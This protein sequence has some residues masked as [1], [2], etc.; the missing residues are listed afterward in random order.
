MPLPRLSLL[1]LALAALAPLAARADELEEEKDHLIQK[2]KDSGSFIA[3]YEWRCDQE[4]QATFQIAAHYKSGCAYVRQINGM[5]PIRDKL[6]GWLR[7]VE[8]VRA[9]GRYK[10]LVNPAGETAILRAQ[11]GYLHN[12][13][14]SFL[15]DLRIVAQELNPGREDAPIFRTP[16]L[17]LGKDS[18]S[19][20]V[21]FGNG[22]TGWISAGQKMIKRND[23]E[24]IFSHPEHGELII[25]RSSGLLRSQQL[26]SELGLMS[27]TLTKVIRK[28]G[29]PEITREIGNLPRGLPSRPFYQCPAASQITHFLFQTMIRDEKPLDLPTHLILREEAFIRFLEK[30]PISPRLG[31]SG[32]FVPLIEEQ[33]QKRAKRLKVPVVQVL[34]DERFRQEQLRMF[35]LN[36]QNLPSAMPAPL[37]FERVLGRPLQARTKFEEF[38]KSQI[39]QFFQHCLLR[40]ELERDLKLY[41]KDL[42]L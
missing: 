9:T 12:G 8:I 20:A 32:R 24:V 30:Q 21:L 3:T 42:G 4:L 22:S 2:L 6:R 5:I 17:L 28:P 31:E 40:T 23:D 16:S 26:N 41:R 25:E 11:H 27:M 1:S 10:M 14:N 37:F 35:A 7:L 36:L 19:L 13:T 18:I 38:R 39:E 34:N 33:A 29:W 15:K